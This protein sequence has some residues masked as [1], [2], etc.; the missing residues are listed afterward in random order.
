MREVRDLSSCVSECCGKESGAVRETLMNYICRKV[1]EQME[2][3]AVASRI[4]QR[5]GSRKHCH[6][7]VKWLWLRQAM[8]ETELW[9]DVVWILMNMM[10][11][12]LVAGAKCLVQQPRDESRGR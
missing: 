10:G 7:E 2:I 1:K 5:L 9:N 12:K 3:C 6:V 11:M 4:G 8:D